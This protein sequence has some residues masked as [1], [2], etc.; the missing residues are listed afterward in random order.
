MFVL[1]PDKHWIY[2]DRMPRGINRK[3][4]P[5]RF[6][7]LVQHLR[8]SSTVNLVDIRDGLAAAASGERLYHLTDTHWNDRGAFIAYQQVMAR[9]A[10]ELALRA[11][12]P[13]TWKS[14]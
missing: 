12:S 4:N 5:P 10:P 11:R 7:Q 9:I 3:I 2:P 6:D 1:A 14:E 13:R 8:H